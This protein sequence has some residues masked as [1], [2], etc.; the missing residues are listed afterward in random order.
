MESWSSVRCVL[1]VFYCGS[2]SKLQI[3][4]G[5]L[6]SG[7]AAHFVLLEGGESRDSPPAGLEMKT[8]QSHC[9]CLAKAC[10][11]S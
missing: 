11:G 6:F 5:Q 1:G 8:A 3:G 4:Y 2:A 9:P 7:I 10:R